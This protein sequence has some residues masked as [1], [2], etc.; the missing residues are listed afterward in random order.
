MSPFSM[1]RSPDSLTAVVDEAE[2]ARGADRRLDRALDGLKGVLADPD[3][4]EYRARDVI[5]R[6]ALVLQASVLLRHGDPGVSEAF[7]ASRMAPWTPAADG[8]AP[9]SGRLYGVL[10]RGLDAAGLVER[11]TPGS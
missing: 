2:T 7:L 6:L 3:D 4:L 10:P 11:A 1:T 5:E 8:A 9:G